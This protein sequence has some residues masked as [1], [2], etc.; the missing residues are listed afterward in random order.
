M[1]GGQFAV[2]HRPPGCVAVTLDPLALLNLKI[3]GK[4][5]FFKGISMISDETFSDFCAVPED[6]TFARG[7]EMLKAEQEKLAHNHEPNAAPEKKEP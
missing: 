3:T 4:I 5:L 7:V 6:L 1:R 2:H